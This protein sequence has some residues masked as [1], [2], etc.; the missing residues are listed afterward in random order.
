MLKSPLAICLFL[1]LSANSFAKEDRKAVV[2]RAKGVI[3]ILKNADKDHDGQLTQKELLGHADLTAFDSD[4]D[5]ALS[6]SE[7]S[8]A[9]TELDDRITGMDKKKEKAAKK[10]KQE[11]KKKQ[12][13]KPGEE[14]K[15][16]A[17]PSEK[18]T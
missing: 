8:A 9:K 13:V 2:E 4:G 14:K 1:A 7:Y 3:E 18:K 16:E 12:E 5:G 15:V 17:K 6:K 11:E 10:K